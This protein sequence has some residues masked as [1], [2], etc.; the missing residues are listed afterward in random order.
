M[1]V[2]K[3]LPLTLSTFFLTFSLAWGTSKPAL[4]LVPG[5]F[6]RASVYSEVTSRLS[7]VG[8]SHIDE[9]DLLSVGYNVADIERTVDVDAVTELLEVRLKDGDDVTLVGNSYGATVIMEAVK[10]F[11]DYSS[12]SVLKSAAQGR[13]LGLIM[14]RTQFTHVSILTDN[15][16]LSGYIPTIAEVTANPPR[17]DIRTIGAPFFNY[18]LSSNGIPTL[19]TWDLN[20]ITYPPHI[21][22]YNLLNTSAAEYWTKQLLP[23]SFKVLN[24]TGTYIPYDGTLRTLYVVGQYDR[25]VSPAFAQS[26]IEKYGALFEVEVIDGDHVPMLSRPEVVVDAIRRFAGENTGSAGDEE[27]CHA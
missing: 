15:C 6:H 20:L 21:T 19:V 9:V 13:I 2:H 17:P 18:H 3:S 8:Y 10:D 26:Y 24:V 22:F 11:E 14:V 23:S 16:Q 4:I 5:A 27:S 7:K 12:G 1:A 25:S